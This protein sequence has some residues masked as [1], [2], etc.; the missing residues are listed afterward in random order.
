MMRRT[1]G[2]TAQ[3]PR[4]G[5]TFAAVS[6]QGNATPGATRNGDPWPAPGFPNHSPKRS[7]RL[8][9]KPL[10]HDTVAGPRRG[11]VVVVEWLYYSKRMSWTTGTISTICSTMHRVTSLLRPDVGEPVRP[12]APELRHAIVV[13]GKCCVPG[14]WGGP[15]SAVYCFSNP[16]TGPGHLSSWEW[17]EN[18]ARAMAI[19][20][21]SC[22]KAARSRP[23]LRR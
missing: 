15:N 10:H 1:R 8:G 22:L 6:V 19:D 23:P 11:V 21:S 7:D 9:T 4:Q 12:R 14:S 18:S 17:C 3:R 2:R 16:P 20:C 5:L 13:E